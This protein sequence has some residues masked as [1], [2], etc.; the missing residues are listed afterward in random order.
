MNRKY[1]ISSLVA[2]G[3]I[4]ST[5]KS[6]ANHLVKEEVSKIK[7]PPYLKPGDTIGI[8]SPAGS[9]SLAGIQPAVQLMES[10]G[11]K[12]TIGS[13]IG[14]KDF[15]YGGTDKER[16][17]DLQQLLDNPAIKAIMCARGGYGI[18]RI[19]DQLDFTEFIKHPKW[20]IGF[21]DVTVLH[22]HINQNFGIATLHSKMCNSFPDDWAQAEPIQISTILSIRQ[23]LAGED[24]KYTAPIAQS[25][26]LG[27]AEG[28]LIGGNLS[29]IASNSG[30]KSDLDTTGKILFLEDTSEYLYNL[31]RM[32]WNLK[33]TGKLAHLAG[34]IIGGFS[35]K[36]DD[37]GEIFGKTIEE[38]VMEKIKEYNYPVCFN[39]PSGHQRA[40]FA[41]KCGTRHL[42]EVGNGG[43]TL[44][45]LK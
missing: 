8:T 9:I 41:L 33:R 12:T 31:D 5:F 35:A 26:R 18:V 19:I 20:L 13:T 15:T 32:F 43:S 22:C 37:P 25:N 30:T 11:Y 38:I 42:L 24:F 40:N 4:F 29:I 2:S 1:F 28:V 36:P 45:S 7:I 21:S 14:K 34:L 3:A 27:R 17:E 6:W 44:S 16:L 23:A 10:W 39:F